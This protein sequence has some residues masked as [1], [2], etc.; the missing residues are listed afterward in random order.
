[1]GFERFKPGS[2]QLRIR[3]YRY[4]V[5]FFLCIILASFVA[6]PKAGFLTRLGSDLLIPYAASI[7]KTRTS[8]HASPV[9]LVVIDEVT[10]QTPPFSE[11]PE[12]AWTPYLGEIIKAIEDAG[13]GVIGLDMIF[14]KTISS[15][16]LL[17]GYD[18]S[19]LQ[20]L[21]SAGRQGKLVLTETRLSDTTIRPYMGQVIAVGGSDNIRPAHLTPDADNIIRRHPAFQPLENG[22]EVYSFAAEL[23][24]RVNAP[25]NNNILIDFTTPTENFPT[26]RFSDLYHCMQAGDRTIF[27]RFA[28]KVVLIGTALDIEDRHV[29]A[30]RLQKNKDFAIISLPCGDQRETPNTQGR[31]STAGVFIEAR[32]VYTFINNTAPTS[33]G[34]VATFLLTLFLLLAT[35]IAFLRLN[36]VYGFAVLTT[37]SA[38]LWFT[39]AQMLADK[40]L[41]PFLPWAFCISILFI[42]IYSYRVILEDQS[43]RWVTHAFRH[44]LNPELVRKLADDPDALRLG[45]ERRRV[46]VLFADLTGFTTTS[47]DM[48]E[49]P[50]ELVAHLNSFF[51][52]IGENIELH[53]GYIDKF[54]GD[55]VMGVWGAPAEIQNPERFAIEAAIDCIKEINVWNLRSENKL[56]INMRIGISAG[57]VVA[58]NLGTPKRFNYTVIG[59]AVNRAARLEQENKRLK[60][61]LLFDA[62]IADQL[63]HQLSAKFIEEVVLRGQ[64]SPTKL[65][66]L[67]LTTE[68]NA[69]HDADIGE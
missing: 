28:N 39:S 52:I 46:V 1:M 57:N 62:N 55:A 47:E 60:T 59:D 51:R 5:A 23:S 69:A 14:P 40:V 34:W 7:A 63:P 21:A 56:K 48:K 61:T 17:P 42:L 12:V 10:H 64:K 67:D 26:Y 16:G 38:L 29:A 37:S 2:S 18:R 31:A 33:P 65:F 13:A 68:I 66:T 49:D 8:D 44:Y 27:D 45:G 11:T 24:A 35:V 54:I 4:P 30:N 9:A 58:G 36:P 43:K 3:R 20:S 22:G 15:R 41:L 32:A 53:H 25:P 50:E 19:F 6:S